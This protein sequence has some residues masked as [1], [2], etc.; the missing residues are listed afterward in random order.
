[1]SADVSKYLALVTSEY[2][3]PNFLAVIT[4][5]VQGH[6]DN[7]VVLAGLAED[8]DLDNA[9]GAQLDAVSKWVGTP[10]QIEETLTGV[11]FSLDVA[12]GLDFGTLAGPFDPLTGLTSL[13]DDTFRTY[14]QFKIAANNWDGTIPGAYTVF[15]NLT[16]LSGTSII[17]QDN[18]DMTMIFALVGNLPNAVVQALF[19]AG[20]LLLKPATVGATLLLPF[21][22]GT[23]YFGLDAENTS[24]SGLDVGAFG[25]V[26]GV[27]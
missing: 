25:I 20:E 5:L 14:L 8:F 24:I 21:A 9:E 4:A 26:A 10:R 13:P 6:A 7:Q 11:Y 1:M 16:P 19:A 2:Q 27:E 22:S 15:A 12:P 17:I 3:K 18:Q 23:P